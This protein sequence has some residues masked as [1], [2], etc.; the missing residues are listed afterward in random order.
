[1][2]PAWAAIVRSAVAVVVTAIVAAQEA[3]ASSA[4]A[5]EVQV[6]ETV[7]AQV[8]EIAVDPEA[9]AL[10]SIQLD[11]GQASSM[12]GLGLLVMVVVGTLVFVL[13]CWFQAGTLAVL[14][15]GEAQAPRTRNAPA[16]VFRTF[17][18]AGFIG[19]ASRYG[20]RIFWVYNL[21]LLFLTLLLVACMLPILLAAWLS[22]D[23][24]L[25]GAQLRSPAKMS[26]RSG[27]K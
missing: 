18:W 20:M 21:F 22:E 26:L 10:E 7:V 1:M 9:K 24:A 11:F 16:A 19:W 6:V 2:V 12:L 4:A 23:G 17:T 8:A 3:V 5:Q 14:L 13:Y 15:A 27:G 25:Q